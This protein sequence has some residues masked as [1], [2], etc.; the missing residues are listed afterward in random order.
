MPAY[1]DPNAPYWTIL[2]RAE[3]EMICDALR[4]AGGNVSAAANALGIA[5]NHFH[6]RMRTLGVDR[7]QFLPGP[8]PTVEVIESPSEASPP[9]N[10]WLYEKAP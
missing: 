9:S 6:K 4:T 3:K 5:R 7:E 8:P 2:A 10:H 1:R